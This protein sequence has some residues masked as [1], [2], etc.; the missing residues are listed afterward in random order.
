VFH[1]FLTGWDIVQSYIYLGEI[2]VARND[3]RV[4]EWIFIQS[5]Q[6]GMEIPTFPLVLDPLIALVG[7]RTQSG[8]IERAL[9]LVLIVLNHSAVIQETRNRTAHLCTELETQLSQ[10]QVESVKA[11]ADAETFEDV[12][13]D[14]LR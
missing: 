11:R 4:A 8:E 6:C 14:V 2:K 3:T 13:G 9:E 1:E 10:Q 12:L 5:V 7:L